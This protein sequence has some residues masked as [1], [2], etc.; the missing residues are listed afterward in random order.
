M[1]GGSVTAL[2]TRLLAESF[3]ATIAD[4][5]NHKDA[6][7]ITRFANAALKLGPLLLGYPAQS[8]TERKQIEKLTDVFQRL[9]AHLQQRIAETARECGCGEQLAALVGPPIDI[10]AATPRLPPKP[11][12]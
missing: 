11:M 7:A 2:L 1:T 4:E 5:V 12:F 3:D 8:A 10:T 9:P 6:N